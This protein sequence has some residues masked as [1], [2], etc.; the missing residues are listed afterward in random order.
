MRAM[1]AILHGIIIHRV[2]QYLMRM[3]SSSSRHSELAKAIQ[4][5][6]LE[7]DLASLQ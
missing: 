1:R 4:V 2:T 7:H 3:G 6:F 5:D